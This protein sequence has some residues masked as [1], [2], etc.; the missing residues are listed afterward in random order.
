MNQFPIGSLIAIACFFGQPADPA[1]EAPAE[2]KVYVPVTVKLTGAAATT[3]VKWKIVPEPAWSEKLP[4]GVGFRFTGGP[5]KYSIRVDYVDFKKELWG[6]AATTVSIVGEGPK[7]EPGPAPEP[8]DPIVNPNT[9][10]KIWV[11]IVEETAD[12]AANRG[13]MFGNSELNA[14]MQSKGHQWRIVDKDVRNVDGQPPADVKRFLDIAKGK[15]YPSVYFVD[16]KGK[17]RA[18]T[19]LTPTDTADKLLGLLKSSDGSK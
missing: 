10:S 3:K 14:Y 9:P 1:L 16:E 4:S 19:N 12:A 17:T 6:E 8:D 15:P 13:A 18:T 11:V 7:P 5:A 2:A